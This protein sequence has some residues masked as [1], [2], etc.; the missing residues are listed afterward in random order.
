MDNAVHI[1][2]I[3]ADGR[4]VPI[5]LAEWNAFLATDP[6]FVRP[7]PDNPNYHLRE[8][9]ALLPTDSANSYDW[10]WIHCAPN[11]IYSEYP[12]QPMLKKIGQIARHFGAIVRRDVGDFCFI[13]ESGEV[14]IESAAVKF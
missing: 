2:R 9:L 3:T 4:P 14:R 7:G 12:Q 11:V 8:S 10:P 6:D 13:D 5:T 1:L